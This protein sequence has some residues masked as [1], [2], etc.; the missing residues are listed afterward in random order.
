MPERPMHEEMLNLIA[1]LRTQVYGEQWQLQFD[2]LEKRIEMAV[3]EAEVTA[4]TTFANSLSAG[5]SLTAIGRISRPDPRQLADD[6]DEHSDEY[7]AAI[8][9]HNSDKRFAERQNGDPQTLGERS[10]P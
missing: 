10:E 1:K 9:E 7:W 3:I 2:L 4:V 8:A 5:A 6:L